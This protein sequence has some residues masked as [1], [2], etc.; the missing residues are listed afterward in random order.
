[1]TTHPLCV[2]DLIVDDQ[3]GDRELQMDVS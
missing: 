2:T 1:M 3:I